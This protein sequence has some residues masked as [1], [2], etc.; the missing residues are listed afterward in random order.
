M[1]RGGMM[2]LPP[3][4]EKVYQ[5]FS[6]MNRRADKLT[7]P[8]NYYFD[9]LN[10]FLRKDVQSGLGFITQRAGS[11]KFNSSA[12]SGF[13]TATPIRTIFEAQWNGGS[14]DIIIRSG[15]CWGKYNGINAF[16]T[17]D[18]ARTSDVVGECVM[19]Q[20]QLIMVDGGIP[21]VMN[22]GYSV[23]NL[24]TDAAM[25]QDSTAVWVHS[26][27][28]W[29]NSTANPM[30]AYFSDT[31]NATTS[32]AWSDTGNAG[33]LDLSTVLPIGDKIIGFKTMGGTTVMI[34][35]IV[36][37]QYLVLYL[38]GADPTQFTLLKYIKLPVLA[39]AGIS[40]LGADLIIASQ[41]EVTSIF[42]AYQNNDLETNGI[43]QWIDPFYRTTVA[44]LTNFQQQ[45]AS[46][47]D[48]QLNHWYL[49]LGNNVTL[50]Y[51]VDVQN[52]VGRWTYPFNIYAWCRRANGTI[53]AASDS[54][55]YTMNTGSDDA[56]TAIQW[57]L[58]MPALYFDLPN[59]YKK[60]VEFEALF[61]ATAS[62][63][64][65]L[66][67]YYDISLAAQPIATK[68]INITTQSSQWNVALWNV[69]YWNQIGVVLYN[70]PDLVGR[71]RAMFI[72]LSHS[73]LDALISMPWF[74]IRY[75]VEGRN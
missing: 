17:I 29:L 25:P 61:Q 22:S 12:L 28:V 26:D 70:T 40:Q 20:N 2:E 16:T 15:T 69:S 41:N 53:L 52:F 58:T 64:L 49:T 51:S 27:K 14:N 36:T 71:G 4:M 54:Y 43:S 39:D 63:Q 21:R 55:V 42:N 60:P 11:A 7:C 75:N 50:I 59:R 44:S 68:T 10:G 47:F 65:T 30:K 37:T 62:L 56:G 38:A 57:Q 24:S 45:V 46:I 3:L 18:T 66:S 6:G 13:G 8:P 67:Y 5:E 31:N 19:F 35:V 34:L 33:Y 72:Q 48:N 73:T 74:V 23:S 9:L 1:P 32:T